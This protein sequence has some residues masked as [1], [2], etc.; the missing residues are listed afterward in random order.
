MKRYERERVENESTY[1]LTFELLWRDY[2]AFIA[3]KHG[4]RLFRRSGLR[5]I[6]L[7]WKH[8]HGTPVDARG[9]TVVARQGQGSGGSSRP[10]A[11]TTAATRPSRPYGFSSHAWPSSTSEGRS[12]P[13]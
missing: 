9:G 5:G 6:E 1:W 11:R 12:T 8:D 13:A 2:F 3:A 4:T 7:P 10:T